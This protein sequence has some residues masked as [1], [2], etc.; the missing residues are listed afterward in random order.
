MSAE[1]P[2]K[3]A[4]DP[5]QQADRLQVL[6]SRLFSKI[7]EN[8]KKRDAV[9]QR[10]LEDLR[11]YN[12]KYD[13]AVLATLE[14]SK[15]S[16]LYVNQT[17]PKTNTL[18]SRL[19]D[20]LYPTDDRN[21]A[22][23]PTP[24]PILHDMANNQEP[25][26]N[27]DGSKFV[28]DQG[29]QVEKRDL[30]TALVKQ[31]EEKAEKMQLAIDDQL[32]EADYNATA[33][34][35]IFDGVMLGT[36]VIKGPTVLGRTRRK[37]VML[38]DGDQS[39]YK[40]ESVK[41]K[42]P[43]T[44]RVD[45]WDFFPDMT[46][47]RLKDCAFITQ[48][49]SYPRHALIKLASEPGFLVNQ[50]RAVIDEE[51]EPNNTANHLA[52]LQAISG[53]SDLGKNR[54]EVWEYHGPIDKADLIACG[55]K[56]IDENDSLQVYTGVIWITEK[57]VIR[58]EVN[59]MDTGEYP[60]SVFNIESDGASLF[61]PGIPRL[62]RNA[63]K[64]ICATWRLVMDNAGLASGDQIVVGDGVE[65][66]DG[67]WQL[68]PRKLWQATGDYH[69]GVRDAFAS[70]SIN[71]HVNELLALFQTA[72]QLADEETGLPQIAQGEQGGATDTFA[73]MSLLMGS[74]NTLL[75][76]VVKNYDDSVTKPLITRFYNW[77]MQF[78]PDESIKGDQTIDARGSSSLMVKEQQARDLASLSQLAQSP[79]L[80]PMTDWYELYSQLVKATG[81]E[82]GIVLSK[83]Q[84][85]ASKD[86]IIAQLQ[87]QVQALQQQA[88]QPSSDPQP[89]RDALEIQKLD[90]QKQKLDQD[91]D[92]A[93]L[94]VQTDQTNR[95]QDNQT[96]V[97]E[98][99]LKRQ[100][101][102]GI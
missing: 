67:N 75:R 43:A 22:I 9:E 27:D 74:A 54:Y 76:R 2:A 65:P 70:F 98:M 5:K 68:T 13:A 25:L 81:L 42:S 72:K 97:A 62:M 18:V 93:V 35:I 16:R 84:I 39:M 40:L 53:L 15:G 8:A 47:S 29:V 88:Q 66:V 90:L 79:A 91:K 99:N 56:G 92:I 44:E 77:N 28:S 61:G 34:E 36:G 41:D 23:K 30:A 85:A 14:L 12:G 10:W 32:T 31:A 46:A 24:V 1:K 49:H 80:A 101:G 100:T 86:A 3:S 55:C 82:N 83:E 52:E 7:T 59:P 94:R 102:Q 87:Q 51:V 71:S 4:I 33:R 6:G 78:N 21:W 45:P 20:I 57:H 26:H 73:G 37:W 19:I 50:I 58:A 60:Y 17:R 48:R 63:Q 89:G 38:T 64:A 69:H 95:Q 11:Q 96:K